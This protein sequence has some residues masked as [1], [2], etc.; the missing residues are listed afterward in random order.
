MQVDEVKPLSHH[1]RPLP[2]L[3]NAGLD[4]LDVLGGL[5]LSVRGH[6][7]VGHVHVRGGLGGRDDWAGAHRRPRLPQLIFPLSWSV[8]SFIVFLEINTPYFRKFL[9]SVHGDAA[10]GAELRYSCHERTENIMK[11]QCSV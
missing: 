9:S 10:L 2:Q 7:D 4:E 11:Y 5:E 8:Q 1:A 3:R 6:G